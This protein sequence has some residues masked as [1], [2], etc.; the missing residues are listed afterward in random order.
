MEGGK[1][2]YHR[3]AGAPAGTVITVRN[4]FYNLP[5]RQKWARSGTSEAAQ[6]LTILN[7]Y[8]LAYP[9]IKFSMVSEGRLLLQTTGSGELR[10]AVTKI[11]GPEAGKAMLEVDFAPAPGGRG[12]RYSGGPSQDG[13]AGDAD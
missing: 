3:P 9:E 2:V 7:N 11:Y 4:L 12:R 8:A 1:Q 10:D 5:A 13:R 6:I